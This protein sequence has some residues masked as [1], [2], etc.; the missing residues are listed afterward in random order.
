MAKKLVLIV[1]LF[2]IVLTSS[3][4]YDLYTAYDEIYRESSGD[5]IEMREAMFAKILSA[6]E[7]RDT[8]EMEELFSIYAKTKTLY[9]E[10]GIERA[11]DFY[12]GQVI[13]C[14][15]GHSLFTAY[16]YGSVAR[17]I[18]AFYWVT[19]DKNTYRLA[20]VYCP[21]NDEERTLRPVI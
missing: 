21:R 18:T 11:M 19:T 12:E 16:H 15:G 2:F 20:F 7:E 17:I 6:L 13:S 14:E 3:S 8:E 9:L 5:E 1:G 4:C 10:H